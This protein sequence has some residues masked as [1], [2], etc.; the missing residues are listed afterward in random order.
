MASLKFKG[1]I[2]HITAIV[3]FVILSAVYFFPQLKG[4]SLRQGDV[5]NYIGTSK[6]I[7]DYRTKFGT[8]PLWTNSMFGG[9]PAYQISVKNTNYIS[10]LE[11][12]LIFKPLSIPLAFLFL[13]MVGFYILLLCFDV[14]P[15]LCV[16]GAIAFGLS[17]INIL[18]LAGGHNTKVHAIALIPPLIGS[19]MLAYRKNLKIGAVLFALFV[20]LELTANHLQM[21]Y[22]ALFLIVPLVLIELFL[23]FRQKLYLKFIN[24][25]AVLLVSAVI[26][27]LPTLTNLLTTYEYSKST[28][29]GK[30]ELT[31]T[32]KTDLF[33]TTD[34]NALTPF[35]IKEYNFGPGE[36]WSLIIPNV[37]GG[38][39]DYIG[40]RKEIIKDV[41]DQYRDI[42]GQ[43]NTYWGEQSGTGGAFYFGAS[44]F[45]LFILGLIFIKDPIKWAILA[46]SL[47]AIFLSLKY[48][49]ILDY[50]IGHFPMFNKFRDTKMFLYLVQI[51]FPFIGILFLKDLFTVKI[52]KKKLLYA[53]ISINGVLFILYLTPTVWFDFLSNTETSQFGAQMNEIQNNPSYLQQFTNFQYELEHARMHIFRNDMIRTLFFTLSI[54]VLVYLFA[55]GKIK[56]NYLIVSIGLLVLIDIWSVD[57]RYLNNEKS[58]SKYR[59]WVKSTESTNPF[60]VTAADNAIISNELNG[61]PELGKRISD[62]VSKM[63]PGSL[64]NTDPEMEKSKIAFRELNFSTNYRVLTLNNPFAN[65]SVSYFHKSIGGYHGAKLKRY[66]EL[67]DFY[68]NPEYQSIIKTLQDSTTTNEKFFSLLQ[69]QIPIIN[70]LNTKYII[71]NPGST[72]IINPYAYGSSW[73]VNDIESVD[74]ANQE[75]QAL[76]T[77]NLKNTAVVNKKDFVS[78]GKIQFDSTSSI[79]QT[80]FLPNHLT[81]ITKTKTNQVAVFS[82]IYFSDGWNAYI[83]GKK[84]SYFRANY[85]L[86]AMVIPAGEH[87]IEFKFE[88]RSYIV[89]ERIS[90][91]SSIILIL[92]VI[93]VLGFEMKNWI[94]K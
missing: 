74:N 9:M 4:L 76:G 78:S 48:S 50:F 36:V 85:L 61:D 57:K 49:F 65:S 93:G 32:S 13:A 46:A 20:C 88:P 39:E 21:T 77:I 31:L 67:I 45:L 90:F 71:S 47:L 51:A 6:E 1:M 25:S 91:A 87:N 26:G 55:L 19:L 62:E 64:K 89:G 7:S 86:R 5:V 8:E 60:Q 17:S 3:L 42:V 94:K 72:P 43:Q 63:I 23:H 28:T 73:F 80:L 66:Q 22:Y 79:K 14:E 69:N 30:S 40:N 37:K 10:N 84:S 53:L 75:M 68:L 35:Y 54:S 29:R 44:M 41:N 58:G 82:E 52:D 59:N 11:S 2:P 15:W 33:K 24:V 81:Y 12:A 56:K 92:I 34:K 38:N 27:A 83:D 18:Y 70:M 16:I